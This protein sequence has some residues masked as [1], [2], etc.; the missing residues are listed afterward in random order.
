MREWVDYKDGN[1]NVY[2]SE[3][4]TDDFI[5]FVVEN[6]D[7]KWVICFESYFSSDCFDIVVENLIVA[8]EIALSCISFKLTQIV[9]EYLRVKKAIEER[10]LLQNDVNLL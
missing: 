6:S 4:K 3:I 9:E 7:N 1:N 10:I 2:K 5:V 8:K